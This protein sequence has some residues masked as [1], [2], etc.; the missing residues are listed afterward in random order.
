[1]PGALRRNLHYNVNMHT[2]APPKSDLLA[3]PDCDLLL[4]QTARA[5][6]RE[7][8][9]PRCNAL[10]WGTGKHSSDIVL[11]GRDGT[12]L[13]SGDGQ[14]SDTQIQELLGLSRERMN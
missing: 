1:M 4:Q 10:L 12:V 6:D 13:F 7:G 14:L 8:R 5:G 11:F 2:A 3:C 9:C